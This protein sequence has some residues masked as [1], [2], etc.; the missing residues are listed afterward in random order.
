MKMW[1]SFSLLIIWAFTLQAQL[2][3][4]GDGP[5]RTNLFSFTAQ[6]LDS[7]MIMEVTPADAAANNFIWDNRLLK[8]YS[9]VFMSQDMNRKFR[10]FVWRYDHELTETE[11]PTRLNN[12]VKPYEVG[13]CQQRQPWSNNGLRGF[14]GQ[15]TSESGRVQTRF[16]AVAKGPYVVSLSHTAINETPTDELLEELTK[17]WESVRFLGK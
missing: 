9:V 2:P 5:L 10:M 17:F 8:I 7:W 1:C 3:E 16:L 15:C 11:K 12:H 13:N 14:T 4:T 6:A